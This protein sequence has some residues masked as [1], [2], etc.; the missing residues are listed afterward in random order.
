M[1]TFGRDRSRAEQALISFQYSSFT[2]PHHW[3][4]SHLTAEV[5]THTVFLSL[6]SAVPQRAYMCSSEGYIQLCLDR[7]MLVMMFLAHLYSKQWDDLELNSGQV[8]ARCWMLIC[9]LHKLFGP[10]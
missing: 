5:V 6:S 9:G 10:N 4:C 3:E 2:Y 1:L 7:R 8:T